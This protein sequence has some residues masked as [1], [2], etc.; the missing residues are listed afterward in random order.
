MG[1]GMDSGGD[2]YTQVPND[3]L[4]AL[5]RPGLTGEQRQTLAAI[6]AANFR[7]PAP[8]EIL[9]S[10]FLAQ[11]TGLPRR[12][13]RRSLDVLIE[14]EVVDLIPGAGTRAGNYLIRPPSA[15]STGRTRAPCRS[16]R[17]SAPTSAIG[18]VLV[19]PLGGAPVRPAAGAPV[20][21]KKR[22]RE[23]D[24]SPGEIGAPMPGPTTQGLAALEV[25]RVNRAFGFY[26]HPQTDRPRHVSDLNGSG[27]RSRMSAIVRDHLDGDRD[28]LP[29]ALAAAVH[30][31]IVRNGLRI[32]STGWDPWQHFQIDSIIN[33]SNFPKNFDAARDAIALG[34]VPPFKQGADCAKSSQPAPRRRDRRPGSDLEG[35]VF[36]VKAFIARG[37][38]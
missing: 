29:W 23:R 35:P 20:R 6:V 3:V 36:D 9:S 2:R 15:W 30:G 31:Y 32:Q 21:P 33:A 11:A 27:R 7:W 14:L 5:A 34:N 17:A 4:A 1:G 8:R 28:R 18:D 26:P 25:E 19:L 38:A 16:G 12:S 24:L 13:V 22:E 37:K 10:R